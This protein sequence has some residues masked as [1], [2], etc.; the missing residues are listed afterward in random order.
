[1]PHAK[2]YD[3]ALFDLCADL[4]VI[5]A[6]D[7]LRD[8][9]TA[10]HA[11]LRSRLVLGQKLGGL[12]LSSAANTAEASRVGNLFLTLHLVVK[13]LRLGEDETLIKRL[14]PEL[15]ASFSAVPATKAFNEAS[16]ITLSQNPMHRVSAAINA[17]KGPAQKARAL[18]LAADVHQRAWI[19][20]C[21]GDGGAWLLAYRP[22]RKDLQ[23]TEAE[24]TALLRVRAGLSPV[25]S[26]DFSGVCAHCGTQEKGK[27]EGNFLHA[28][29]CEHHGK[30]CPAA[31]RATRH[32][33]V[34]RTGLRPAIDHIHRVGGHDYV[35]PVGEPQ[36]NHFWDI[37]PNRAPGEGADRP[38]GDWVV[39]DKSGFK[40][41]CDLVVSHTNANSPRTIGSDRVDGLAAAVAFKEKIDLYSRLYIIHPIKS[42]VPI[43]IETGGRMHETSKKYLQ[44][45]CCRL[46]GGDPKNW[47]K[48]EQARYNSS[49]RHLMDSV[50][51]ALAK[52]VA[53]ALIRFPPSKRVEE[54]VQAQAAAFMQQ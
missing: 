31:L 37:N 5:P 34:A 33:Q 32:K 25:Q 44:T 27:L 23:L 18:A 38:R 50:S 17:L 7:S 47:S 52:S 49:I 20:S 51:L 8:R 41:V 28:L 53:S 26:Y 45:I 54:V 4:L 46:V 30:G 42:F 21:G 19:R 15:D 40:V 10:A 13:F 22:W 1:M 29:T 43:S 24:Y 39:V 3:D 12:Q 2:R 6:N 35:I 16:V 48:K 11:A 36:G 14:V 9:D